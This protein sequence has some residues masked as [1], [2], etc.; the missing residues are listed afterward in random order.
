MIK[1]RLA[2]VE[3]MLWSL[4]PDYAE[5]WVDLRETIIASYPRTRAFLRRFPEEHT[6]RESR[7]AKSETGC[8]STLVITE[9]TPEIDQDLGDEVHYNDASEFLNLRSRSLT[10]KPYRSNK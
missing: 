5:M 9:I 2:R 4:S 6:E 10:K 8:T 7:I 1:N 3:P